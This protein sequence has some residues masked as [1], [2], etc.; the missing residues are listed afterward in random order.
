MVKVAI[1]GYLT[2]HKLAQALKAIV[3][4]GWIASEL[5][6]PHSNRR[7]DMAFQSV[8]GI[9]VV[10]YDGDAHYRHSL[11]IKAD[12]E[13][14]AI[15]SE[16]GYKTIRF[17]YWVQL[18]GMTLEH[19]F[20]LEAEIAQDFPHGFITTRYFP[21][22][23][24][25]VGVARFRKELEDLPDAVRLKVVQSLHDRSKEYGTEYVMPS[26]LRHLINE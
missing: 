18:D 15:A 5:K 12:R 9:V 14:D 10:E 22:S 13:K 21:A 20:R 11:K 8:S 4:G 19:F 23:F 1:E 17:P 6:I 24:C 16:L 7:W 3:G 25:E 26:S 2:Q